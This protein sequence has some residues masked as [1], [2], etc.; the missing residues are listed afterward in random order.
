MIKKTDI[1]RELEHLKKESEVI[2]K[3]RKSNQL[4]PRPYR[5]FSDESRAEK[6][7]LRIRNG[8]EPSREAENSFSFSSLFQ[9]TQEK[10]QKAELNKM[11]DIHFT[12]K[13]YIKAIEHY[14][15]LLILNS[16]FINGHIF[17]GLALF[18]VKS[19][20]KALVCFENALQINSSNSYAM[21]NRSVVLYS[22]GRNREALECAANLLKSDAKFIGAFELMKEH[23]IDV[24][25]K[26]RELYKLGSYKESLLGYEQLLLTSNHLGGLK[27]K[28][29]IGRALCLSK[30]G[31]YSEALKYFDE[32]LNDENYLKNAFPDRLL[33]EMHINKGICIYHLYGYEMALEY[34]TNFND[35]NLYPRELM[36]RINPSANKYQAVASDNAKNQK[37]VSEENS[38][39]HFEEFINILYQKSRDD[40]HSDIYFKLIL[41]IDPENIK[42][43][44]SWLRLC[45]YK[46]EPFDFLEKTKT[47][48][49]LN[50]MKRKNYIEECVYFLHSEYSYSNLIEFCEGLEL[51]EIDDLI[52]LKKG[53][54]LSRLK[55][56]QEALSCFDSV[57]ANT[58]K[59]QIPKK[60][61]IEY[62]GFQNERGNALYHLGRYSEALECFEIECSIHHGRINSKLEKYKQLNKHYLLPDEGM[63]L[64]LDKLKSFNEPKI[65]ED[66]MQVP[67]PPPIEAELH[68]TLENKTSAEL[69][70][71]IRKRA[72]TEVPESLQPIHSPSKTVLKNIP[73]SNAGEIKINQ[74]QLQFIKDLQ[75]SG[76]QSEMIQQWQQQLSEFPLSLDE[77]QHYKCWVKSFSGKIK[78][79]E[80]E[81]NET[82][83]MLARDPQTQHEQNHINGRLK[84][85]N[86]HRRLQKEL[87]AFV[88]CYFL[89]PADIFKLNDNMKDSAIGAIGSI[90]I[91]GQFLKVLTSSLSFANKKYRIYQMNRL[92][93]L[94]IDLPHITQVI[95]TFARQVTIAQEKVI[96]QKTQPK[97]KGL[98]KVKEFFKNVKDKLDH[99][100]IKLVTEDK[101]ALLDAAYLL[102]Q[103]LSGDA[104][105]DRNQDLASQFVK[106]VTEEV[107][108]PKKFSDTTVIQ[109]K[110]VVFSIDPT[111]LNTLRLP[112][113]T[114]SNDASQALS[115]EAVQQLL[116]EQSRVYEETLRKQQEQFELNKQNQEKENRK[117]LA[118]TEVARK[119]AEA[120]QEDIINIKKSLLPKN[121]EVSGSTKSLEQLDPPARRTAESQ[122]VD[123]SQVLSKHD[124]QIRAVF[125]EMAVLKENQ[126]NTTIALNNVQNKTGIIPGKA[127]SK[128]MQ[129]AQYTADL[130]A[131]K[132]QE[133]DRIRT[134][135]K[136]KAQALLNRGLPDLV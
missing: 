124:D 30:L 109:T 106:V 63:N 15:K 126:K 27:I 99:P 131:K 32:K 24:L 129:I 56:Y 34:F 113:T 68:P 80:N 101:M 26:T 8:V 5:P 66:Q 98:T 21:F 36:K 125:E 42:T 28:A 12:K 136:R 78:Q 116:K 41:I 70:Q 17:K 90:P 3:L 117:L 38:K 73:E 47:L 74:E 79:L 123:T 1:Q 111:I 105:I 92:N 29:E 108:Q 23:I 2:K 9:S 122:Q 95:C 135:Q 60:Y 94:F 133:E 35:S 49:K 87:S 103:I 45:R 11:A 82:N 86:Y 114:P 53:I 46:R 112:S 107:Y 118:E 58:T 19:Y 51:N 121:N 7:E 44:E 13:E 4:H 22:L 10:Q 128:R 115:M 96:E 43:L 84:L 127:E 132:R 25:G 85:K 134:E 77:L 48:M 72:K 104:K 130:E 81:I 83:L 75:A 61:D 100:G 110:S 97:S 20:E 69:D 52:L 120:A 6:V 59:E 65:S 33:L 62:C 119:K 64:C 55:R 67:P 57:F 91:A 50:P 37:S 16:K 54:A 39:K 31:R 93:E 89:A 76:L 88:T 102:E 14:D 71:S 40:R 18:R